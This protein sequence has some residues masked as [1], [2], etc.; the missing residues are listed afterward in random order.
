[1]GRHHARVIAAD[2]R[3]RLV[4]AIDINPERSAAIAARYGAEAVDVV[5]DGVEVVVVATPTVTHVEVARP[6]LAEG[7]WCL[8]EKPLA[9]TS[10]AA[11]RLPPARLAVG[12]V[13]RFNPAVRAAGALRPLYVEARRTTPPTG[14]S[15]DIDVVL[16]LMLHDLDLLLVW[17]GSEIVAIDAVG[18]TAGGRLDAAN[19]RVRLADGTT[20]SLVASRVADV[21]E[22]YVRVVEE[23]R[24]TEL[25]LLA[26]RAMRD[27]RV[28]EH[29]GRDGLT[30]Q[31]QAFVAAVQGKAPIAVDAAAGWRAVA[32]AE[33]VRAAVVEPA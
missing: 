18:S 31:W 33:R 19:V 5:P 17:S 20:A 7:R 32:V 21:A 24:R 28:L 22:R 11:A 25:D 10:L 4:A 6:L 26:G 16:D 2:P 9:E 13:E 1:M 29:D 15:L 8:V 27:G 12:H 23:G 14:R 30:A 3:C